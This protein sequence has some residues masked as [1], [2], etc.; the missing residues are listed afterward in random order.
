[1]LMRLLYPKWFGFSLSPLYSLLGLCSD[2]SNRLL[3][4]RSCW[5]IPVVTALRSCMLGMLTLCNFVFKK[6]IEKGKSLHVL[7]KNVVKSNEFNITVLWD[8]NWI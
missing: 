7:C 1:M 8:L 5:G 6:H 2:P 3:Q 4:S